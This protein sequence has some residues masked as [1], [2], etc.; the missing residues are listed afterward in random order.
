V[1]VFVCKDKNFSQENE[2][3][4]GKFA[5]LTRIIGTLIISF[6]DNYS[7]PIAD[8]SQKGAAVA[9]N[10]DEKQ[11]NSCF[12]LKTAITLHRRKETNDTI[13]QT[14]INN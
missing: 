5:G 9:T 8:L 3:K 2:N 1:S 13:K 10:S 14:F 6:C 7:R 12:F 4:I 11:Q